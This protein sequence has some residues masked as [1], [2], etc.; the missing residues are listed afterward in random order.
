M[1]SSRHSVM[2]VDA[3]SISVPENKLIKILDPDLKAHINHDK[4]C[5]EGTRVKII[6][7]ISNKENFDD[8]IQLNGI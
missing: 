1:V 2:F 4:V 7:E 3:L 8:I 6:Q 5:L